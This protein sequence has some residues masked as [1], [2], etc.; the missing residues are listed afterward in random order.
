MYQPVDSSRLT[1]VYCYG[2]NDTVQQIDIQSQRCSF[3]SLSTALTAGGATT[4]PLSDTS[5]L[6]PHVRVRVGPGSV[7]EL[8]TANTQS[9]LRDRA[10]LLV[11]AA[12]DGNFA[13]HISVTVSL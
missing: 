7:C 6:G 5:V 9:L 12:N 11:S 8:V 13:L 2:P 3:V 1:L 10:C 4:L